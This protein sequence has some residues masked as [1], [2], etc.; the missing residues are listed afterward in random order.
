MECICVIKDIYRAIND[1]EEEFE[2]SFNICINEGLVLCAL[3][4]KS[5]SS[6][7]I[8]E[9]AGL[10]F[11][12]ASK[13]IKS[14]EDKGYIDRSIGSSDKRYMNFKLTELGVEMLNRIK[15]NPIEIPEMLQ[16][17]FKCKQQVTTNI[18]W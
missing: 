5:L 14:V 3:S 1:F 18:Q 13:L 2:K 8:A 10:K 6:S 11:S 15:S 4:E 9:Q 17:V 7:E 12:H 16:P